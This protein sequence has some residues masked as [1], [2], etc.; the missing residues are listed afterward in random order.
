MSALTERW[1]VTRDAAVAALDPAS[2]MPDED[3]VCR[4]EDLVADFAV[5][6]P[7]LGQRIR[8]R[9]GHEV[10]DQAVTAARDALVAFGPSA[11]ADL[12]D[13]QVARPIVEINEPRARSP[14][15]PPS[16]TSVPGSWRTGTV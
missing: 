8:A 5:A 4:I 2:D 10:V 7:E 11:A 12:L 13:R 9:F 1:P 3:A 6:Q 16:P 14:P 15:S